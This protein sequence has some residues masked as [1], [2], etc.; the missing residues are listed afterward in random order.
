M[1]H[2]LS[3]LRRLAAIA[4]AGILASPAA[5]QSM[6]STET[7]SGVYQRPGMSCTGGEPGAPGGPV[8]IEEDGLG[9]GGLRCDFVTRVSVSRMDA[10]LVDASC[11]FDTPTATRLFMSRGRGGVTIVSRELGTF[12]LE[13]CM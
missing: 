10:L 4:L 6:L 5:A 1:L 3:D 11:R 9:I 8:L 7:L 2:H 12:V 13:A